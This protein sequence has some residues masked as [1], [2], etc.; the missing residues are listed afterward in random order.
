MN[1]DICRFCV[2]FSAFFASAARRFL[3]EDWDLWLQHIAI[4]QLMSFH[5]IVLDSFLNIVAC[6][7]ARTGVRA[8]NAPLCSDA[9]DLVVVVVPL[10]NSP[11]VILICWLHPHVF[12]EA[13]A[14]LAWRSLLYFISGEAILVVCLI[15]PSWSMLVLH[16]DRWCCFYCY[17]F[18]GFLSMLLF[19]TW[20]VGCY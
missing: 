14:L 3:V 17:C 7:T 6:S 18:F 15:L 16:L 13:L 11:F 20:I 2:I 12:R 4:L 9:L 19:Q 5:L 8:L 10:I 1:V